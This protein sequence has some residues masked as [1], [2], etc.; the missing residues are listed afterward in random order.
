[1]M[2]DSACAC[3]CA[4]AD[5]L[6]LF[7]LTTMS[8]PLH[9]PALSRPSSSTER[10]SFWHLR[11]GCEVIHKGIESVQLSTRYAHRWYAPQCSA[12]ASTSTSS[13]KRAREGDE[14][15]ED[16]DDEEG[17][18]DEE[19]Y[20]YDEGEYSEEV[21]EEDTS[22]THQ[23]FTGPVKPAHSRPPPSSFIHP[24]RLDHHKNHSFK[25]KQTSDSD[26]YFDIS[27]WQPVSSTPQ[28]K[29]HVI[30]PDPP[31]LENAPMQDGA[32]TASQ[33]PQEALEKALQ[34]W[35]TAGYAAALYH[36]RSGLVKP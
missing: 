24:S 32:I 18:D 6:S 36:V 10:P 35:Y 4:I 29:Q 30:I 31:P 9:T 33:P 21:Q 8:S 27:E 16:V 26:P 19:E 7:P 11:C 12:Q 5:L 34:A 13:A 15:E 3:A 23:V 17:F 20:E 22:T 14:Q 1:M 28:E 25:L 2:D